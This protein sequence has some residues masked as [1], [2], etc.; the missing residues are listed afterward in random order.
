M[1]LTPEQKERLSRLEQLSKEWLDNYNRY[2][3]GKH[4]PDMQ[5]QF[6]QVQGALQRAQ[7]AG[8]LASTTDKV[9]QKVKA[10]GTSDQ[11]VVAI[12]DSMSNLW[13]SDIKDNVTSISPKASIDKLQSS[14]NEMVKLGT[15]FL[16]LAGKA[17]DQ[18]KD[19]VS[20]AKNWFEEGK[21][22]AGVLGSIKNADQAWDQLKKAWDSAALDNLVIND[23]KTA[24]R[25][26]TVAE[27]LIRVAEVFVSIAR[28]IRD[29]TWQ[30]RLTQAQTWLNRAKEILAIA[31]KV[32]EAMELWRDLLASWDELKGNFKGGKPVAKEVLADVNAFIDAADKFV[33]LA[34]DIPS[35]A[36]KVAKVR[37]WLSIAKLATGAAGDVLE[38]VD[39]AQELWAMVEQMWK[40]FGSKFSEGK[41]DEALRAIAEQFVKT[42]SKFIDAANKLGSEKWKTQIAQA[43]QY[44][45]TVAKVLNIAADALGAAQ[46]ANDLWKKLQDLWKTG[47]ASFK[48]GVLDEKLRTLG[49]SLLET[50]EAFI[51][52]ASK[53]GGEQWAKPLEDAR[54]WLNI[55]KG[56]LNAAAG[57]LEAI[58]DAELLWTQ[59]QDLWKNL[60]PSFKE[61]KLDEAFRDLATNFKATANKFIDAA[62]QIPGDSWKARLDQVRGYIDQVSKGI[63]IAADAIEAAQ[64][65]VTLWKEVEKIWSELGKSFEN[66]T[67]SESLR[68][69]AVNFKATA[70]KFVAVAEKIAGDTWKARLDQAR[71]WLDQVAKG[72]DIAADVVDA[73]KDA[74][75]LWQEVEKTWSNLSGLFKDGKLDKSLQSIA[76][77]FKAV[78][79]RFI[80]AANRI[81]NEAWK[82]KVAIVEGYLNQIAKGIEIA[83][84]VVDAAKDAVA[85]WEE[86]TGIW[87]KLETSFKDGKLGDELRSVAVN[88]KV[89]ADKFVAAANKIEDKTWQARVS[90]VQ[91]WLDTVAKGIDIA[92]DVVD[93]VKAAT[94][95]W[96]E[97]TGIWANL[98]KAFKAG[99]LDDDLRSLGA[100]FKAV[101][102]KFVAAANKIEDKTWQDRVSQVQT[103]LDT[104]AKGIDIAADAVEAAQDAMVL[105]EQV[106]KIWS[107][108]NPMLKAGSLGDAL[109]DLSK[110]FQEVADKF[111]A[112]AERINNKTWLDKVGQVKQWLNAVSLAI[113]IAGDVVDAVKDAEALWQ[114]VQDLWKG[115][116]Q[117]FKD[118]KLDEQLRSLAVNFKATAG[119]F[120]DAAA[121]IPDETW[122]KRVED[123]RA[124]LDQVAKGIDIAADVVDAAKD[125]VALWD[126]LQ[127]LWKGLQGSFKEGKLD[128]QLRSLATQFTGVANKFIAAAK[129]IEDPTWQKRVAE[130]EGFLDQVAKGINIAAD[131]VEAAQDAV[132]LWKEI[133]KLWAE[134]GPAFKEGKLD[135]KLRDIAT[136]FTAVSDKFLKVAGQV[137]GDAWKKEIELVQKYRDG[138]AKGINIA[139]DA[140]AAANDAVALWNEIEKLWSNLGPAFKDGK[141]GEELRNLAVQFKATAEKFIN[142]AAQIGGDAWADKVEKAKSYLDTLS[143]GIEIA[144]DAVDAA[145]GA[146]ELW[147]EVQDLWSNLGPAFEKGNLGEEL[148]SFATKFSVAAER[149]VVVAEKIGGDAWKD[150][151][152]KTRTWLD[153]VKKGIEIAGDAIDAAKSAQELWEEV[154]K[155]WS[156]LG[157]AFQKGELG[158]ELRKTATKFE[159]TANKFI[160]V[161][162]KINGDAWKTQISNVRSYLDI[163][164]KGLLAAADVAEGVQL[165]RELWDDVKKTIEDFD[166]LYSLS[167]FGDAIKKLIDKGVDAAEKF[168][169]AAEKVGGDAWKDQIE[170]AKT[171]LYNARNIGEILMDVTDAADQVKKLWDELQATWNGGKLMESIKAGQGEK[172]ADQFVLTAD[173]IIALVQRFKLDQFQ[174]AAQQ[175]K[176]WKDTVAVIIKGASAVLKGA[177]DFADDIKNGDFLA[178]GQKIVAFWEKVRGIESVAP[179]SIDAEM[180]KKIHGVQDQ[181]ETWL[182]KAEDL[183]GLAA[184][185]IS[186]KDVTMLVTQLGS[187][188]KQI[189]VFTNNVK[190]LFNEAKAAISNGDVAKIGEMLERGLNAWEK[191]KTTTGLI[192]NANLDKALMAK[193]HE[194]QEYVEDILKI[195]PEEVR[196]GLEIVIRNARAIV[197]EAKKF[198]AETKE[199]IDDLK[200]GKYDK[201]YAYFK[202]QIKKFSDIRTGNKKV[203]EAIA[204]QITALKNNVYTFVGKTVLG[205]LGDANAQAQTGKDL[206]AAVD[207][208]LEWVL[209]STPNFD[210][211]SYKLALEDTQ[212]NEIKLPKVD[213]LPKDKSVE[214]LNGLVDPEFKDQSRKLQIASAIGT[215]TKELRNLDLAIELK[216]EE[217]LQA[218]ESDGAIFAKETESAFNVIAKQ[219][220]AFKFFDALTNFIVGALITIGTSLIAA[221]GVGAP[222]AAAIGTGAGIIS[223]MFKRSTPNPPISEISTAL[224]ARFKEQ[225]TE[226]YQLVKK[227]LIAL[228]SNFESIRNSLAILNTDQEI[229]VFEPKL[230]NQIHEFNALKDVIK[231]A[232][233]GGKPFTISN[234]A[235]VF[236]THR[237]IFFHWLPTLDVSGK[238]RL[239]LTKNTIDALKAVRILQDAGVEWD[240][241]FWGGVKR[242]FGSWFNSLA[243][244]EAKKV[245]AMINLAKKELP[246]MSSM[247]FWKNAPS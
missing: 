183:T 17:G 175:A 20:T 95:L 233:I 154:S 81:E 101:A 223:S 5:K 21:R 50:G 166:K 74:V 150:Q 149:F 205:G 16:S 118:G 143:K 93:A 209:D 189:D 78:A 13:N 29:E 94:E 226:R 161:A 31:R 155:L 244:E 136:Q 216:F 58:K 37:G 229:A 73:A 125:A 179:G 228:E 243:K 57:G 52:V 114:E 177:M 48:L 202:N 76:A 30:Q 135:E 84:D 188:R 128:E 217:L 194:I 100:S 195:I 119:R 218:V 213:A 83:A 24:I 6:S 138:V 12:W 65:A 122:K 235:V 132:A 147:K 157:P 79:E 142:V 134:L 246:K 54:K 242:W 43:Q 40:N 192:P 145:K 80:A 160:E 185:G 55:A 144:A 77:N 39:N 97:V 176:Q 69:L 178:A 137:G 116:G 112:A 206:L 75:A 168:V 87:S 211:E 36:D 181:I 92:A 171:F 133:E 174:Q 247:N 27:N 108:L 28:L 222:I 14:A 198:I 3:L 103:W 96:S 10:V 59:V 204:N 184:L 90:Q 120:L 225:V 196:I 241:S 190:E 236:N 102:D 180:W 141:L 115:L 208:L 19:K 15:S 110:Q 200:N 158:E 9:K 66:G 172:L 156:N 207:A 35:L 131:A 232:Y 41:A 220:K 38:G 203:D 219:Q 46:K 187:I 70:E 33:A 111:I 126:E 148:R 109:R 60:G 140:V 56:V 201:V 62:A 49:D 67:L 11:K 22:L 139:A 199:M 238:L 146:V 186:L 121:R 127:T 117:S 124:W 191:L 152:A 18:V 197:E 107:N 167:D 163:A 45:D 25:I 82:Q 170:L 169:A 32:R 224:S 8:K 210:V 44:I 104:V 159:E 214:L 86:V 227:A 234:N 4:Y 2:D 123:V 153:K 230:G 26:I 193:V 165:L 99:K 88:F 89:V 91:T 231:S 164:K 182:K 240:E 1:S 245:Q 64:D 47:E 173:K 72:I 23:A 215:F 212:E 105:W 85:L 221:T 34:A 129:R 106:Q 63:E 162:E 61:G 53:I 42:A 7:K 98:D 68:G 239:N 71:S 51:E 151:V 113:D 237:Y 130:A